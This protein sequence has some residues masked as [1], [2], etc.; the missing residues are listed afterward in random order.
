MNKTALMS[1]STIQAIFEQVPI[2]IQ[3]SLIILKNEKEEETIKKCWKGGQRKKELKKK[4]E[5]WKE[6]GREESRE[7]VA[8]EMLR[9]GVQRE[10]IMKV[11]SFDESKMDE[12]YEVLFDDQNY[13]KKT[14]LLERNDRSTPV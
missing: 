1:F 2:T 14:P 3:Q 4:I 10:L 9:E 8:L 12:L 13:Q 6:E 5:A 7:E 11:T